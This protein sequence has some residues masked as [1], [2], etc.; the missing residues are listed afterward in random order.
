MIFREFPLPALYGDGAEGTICKLV[1]LC[2]L[3]AQTVGLRFWP[4]HYH[5]FL[6]ICSLH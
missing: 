5:S 6:L 3:I 1:L 4:R 2:A